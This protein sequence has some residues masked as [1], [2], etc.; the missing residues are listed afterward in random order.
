MN[1]F[2]HKL[3]CLL[4]CFC[5][6]QQMSANKGLACK[7]QY[8]IIES[9]FSGGYKF[10]F[11]ANY[12]YNST[13]ILNQN[14]YGQ[15]GKYELNYKKDFGSGYGFD[16]GIDFKN[17]YGIQIGYIINSEEGQKYQDIIK[18]QNT[19]RTVSLKYSKIPLI[20]KL[21]SYISES[22]NPIIFNLCLGAQYGFLKSA[23]DNV[24]GINTDIFDKV[25]KNE[26]GIILNLESDFYLNKFMFLTFGFNTSIGND[27]NPPDWRA[28]GLN[29]AS[30]N[31]L[32]GLNLGLNY[33]FK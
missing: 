22:E 33:C 7:N 30:H 29:G 5:S 18:H 28:S 26:F 10:Y 20:I 31:L 27:I 32:L 14:T 16:A 21:K 23:N 13:W 9:N 2:K 8:P 6:M 12:T 1:C 11:G 19:S 4:F 25:K 3:I 15:F 24:N 17:K